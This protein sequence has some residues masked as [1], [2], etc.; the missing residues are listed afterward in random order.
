MK[1]FECGYTSSLDPMNPLGG[2]G[3]YC[4]GCILKLAEKY[5]EVRD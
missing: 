3:F 4:D 2:H 5:L 1:C